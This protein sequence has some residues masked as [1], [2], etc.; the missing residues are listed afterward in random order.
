MRGDMWQYP[1]IASTARSTAP[2]ST[3]WTVADPHI[4]IIHCEQ[5]H[6][7][8]YNSQ[9]CPLNLSRSGKD[10]LHDGSAI[11]NSLHGSFIWSYIRSMTQS[12]QELCFP[13]TVAAAGAHYKPVPP[14]ERKTGRAF[15]LFRTLSSYLCAVDYLDGLLAVAN[16]WSYEACQPTEASLLHSLS[17]NSV[18]CGRSS[19]RHCLN[20]QFWLG[21]KHLLIARASRATNI[22]YGCSELGQHL[23]P[24]RDNKIASIH[25][26]PDTRLK[27]VHRLNVSHSRMS[28][29]LSLHSCPASI[30]NGYTC[31]R[32]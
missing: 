29:I 4:Y 22:I 5:T 12:E 6:W 24:Q 21:I 7:Y 27:A 30:T 19:R 31:V 9:S 23:P 18:C 1:T 10:I 25:C 15:V 20:C 16:S 2:R 11:Q 26:R 32:K 8:W 17:E 28:Q 14:F 3:Q 13:S